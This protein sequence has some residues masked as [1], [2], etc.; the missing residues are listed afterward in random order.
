MVAQVEQL[1]SDALAADGG[2][3]RLRVATEADREGLSALYGRGS[4]DA[5]R[6]RFFGP[7][8]PR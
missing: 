5:L 7:P 1:G 6:L 4:A 3:I 8:T 2:I